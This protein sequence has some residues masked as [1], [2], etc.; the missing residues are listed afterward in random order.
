MQTELPFIDVQIKVYDWICMVP[1]RKTRIGYK[2]NESVLNKKLNVYSIFES[3]SGSRT[4]QEEEEMNRKEVE[5]LEGAEELFRRKE[6][7]NSTGDQKESEFHDAKGL[8]EV[9]KRL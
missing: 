3:P 1:S 6:V 2:Q 7:W 9:R 4:K 5:K 8:N